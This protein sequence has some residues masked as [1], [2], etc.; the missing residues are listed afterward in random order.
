MKDY[1]K[2]S[3]ATNIINNLKAQLEET[4]LKV[5]ETKPIHLHPEYRALVKGLETRHSKAMSDLEAEMKKKTRSPVSQTHTDISQHPDYSRLIK[6]WETQKQTDIKL[7]VNS[8]VKKALKDN[9]KKPV[10]T[11]TFSYQHR[12]PEHPSGL[13]RESPLLYNASGFPEPAGTCKIYRA[14]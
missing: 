12:G 2:K 9:G 3:E 7:A 6:Q 10:P 8:A 4:T 11:S 14:I 5:K 1:I 13:L